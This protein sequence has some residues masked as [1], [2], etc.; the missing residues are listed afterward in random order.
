MHATKADQKQ[1]QEKNILGKILTTSV[2]DK[3][4]ISLLYKKVP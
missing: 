3:G 4:L 2:I 1:S